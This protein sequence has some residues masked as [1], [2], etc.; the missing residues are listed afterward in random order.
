VPLLHSYRPASADLLVPNIGRILLLDLA[1][2]CMRMITT[3][4]GR[5]LHLAALFLTA[6]VALPRAAA[7]PQDQQ[8]QSVADAARRARE[9]KKNTAKSSKVITDDDIESKNPKP[10]AGGP[11]AGAPPK[12]DAQ[13]ASTGAAVSPEAADRAAAS[14]SKDSGGKTAGGAEIV[15]LKGQIAQIQKDLDLLQREF[16]LDRD[17]YYSQT[18]FAHDKSG[19][20][21]LDAE[22]QLI[23]DKQEQID[24]L[25]TR[26]A[27]V[28]EL[29]DRK[30]AA[31]AEASAPPAPTPPQP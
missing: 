9:Q 15:K 26:L 14:A 29:Q 17:S 20:A 2:T 6:C 21:K 13:P 28:Q 16:V 3:R 10:S 7:Q 12:I 18:D 5:S 11:D 25:K 23:N 31:S 27:A 22:Q 24:A 4:Y 19:K 1:E 8:T 30:K